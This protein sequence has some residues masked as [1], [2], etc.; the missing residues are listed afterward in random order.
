MRITHWQPF[1]Q[2]GSLQSQIDDVFA[3]LASFDPDRGM[4]QM[5]AVDIRETDDE[6]I[7][8]ARLSGVD[9][10]NIDIQITSE[11]VTL[12]GQHRSETHYGYGH[13]FSYGG[14]RQ[15]IALPARVQSDQAHVDFHQGA[16]ILTMLKANRPIKPISTWRNRSTRSASSLSSIDTPA[17]GVQ[18]QIE[19]LTKGWTKAKHWLG[20]QLQTAA[21]QLLAD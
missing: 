15:A 11:A 17:D 8:S 4:A 18:N 7:L 16:L 10:R 6:V 13:R 20:R 21:D 19:T 1:W 5:A 3:E 12:T 9:P 2:V 14:F